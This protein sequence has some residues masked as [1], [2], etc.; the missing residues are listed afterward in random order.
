MTPLE[1]NSRSIPLGTLNRVGED[2]TLNFSLGLLTSDYSIVLEDRLTGAL[3]NLVET[4][5]YTYTPSTT[6]KTSDRFVIHINSISTTIIDQE[7]DSLEGEDQIS[8]NS[9]AGTVK[10]KIDNQL[11]QTRDGRIEVYLLDGRKIITTTLTTP[12]SE[13]VLPQLNAMFVVKVIAGEVVKC[14]LILG[15]R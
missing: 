2:V 3:V 5:Y 6:N 10:V 4:P 15:H 11:L 7:E 1:L 13:V 9:I 8:I 14:K 12:E